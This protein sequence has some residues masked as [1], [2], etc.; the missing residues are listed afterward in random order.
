MA[1]GTQNKDLRG[2]IILKKMSKA[3]EERTE[4]E[5]INVR[6]SNKENKRS[7]GFD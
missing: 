3:A 7:N 1:T 6:V 2:M 5:T 4:E